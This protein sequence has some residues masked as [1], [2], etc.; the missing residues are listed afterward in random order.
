MVDITI[1]F[2]ILE[3]NTTISKIVQYE[4]IPA[5][6]SFF[7][8]DNDGST[9]KI[10]RHDKRGMHLFFLPGKGGIIIEGYGPQFTEEEIDELVKLGWEVS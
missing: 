1:Y 5:V 10:V 9:C 6:G 2:R 3:T 4:A 8:Y 7:G